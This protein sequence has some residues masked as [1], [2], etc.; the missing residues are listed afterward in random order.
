M[1]HGPSLNT[2]P[3]ANSLAYFYNCN[4]DF[5]GTSL[6]C[7]DSNFLAVGWWEQATACDLFWGQLK[8]FGHFRW[9]MLTPSD[10]REQTLSSILLTLKCFKNWNDDN[11][12]IWLITVSLT[13]RKKTLTSLCSALII[14]FLISSCLK[15][16]S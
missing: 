2:A 4:L 12:L 13:E 1:I 5:M 11:W 6:S 14:P 15:S 3:G 9:N 8:I 16:G 10:S 7:K